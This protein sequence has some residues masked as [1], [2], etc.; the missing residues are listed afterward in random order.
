MNKILF[1]GNQVNSRKKIAKIL[2]NPKIAK[3]VDSLKER[4]EVINQFKKYSKGGITKDETRKILGKFYYN[5]NDSLDRNEVSSLAQEFGIGGSHKYYRSNNRN[6]GVNA[7]SSSRVE[8]VL[9]ENIIKSAPDNA[10]RK[11]INIPRQSNYLG[12]RNLH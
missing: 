5:R 7:D 3:I 4:N 11:P 6:R 8:K 1:K 9:R 2:K 12:I 10:N